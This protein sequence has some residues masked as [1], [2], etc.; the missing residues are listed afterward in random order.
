[1]VKLPEWLQIGK[2]SLKVLSQRSHYTELARQTDTDTADADR[3][4]V[5]HALLSSHAGRARYSQCRCGRAGR[6][7]RAVGFEFLRSGE[8]AFPNCEFM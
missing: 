8:I 3:Y 2:A 5:D 4:Q 1:M 7:P 6:V